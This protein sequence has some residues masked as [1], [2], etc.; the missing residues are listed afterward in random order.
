M[1]CSCRGPLLLER[2]LV[3]ERERDPL[4]LGSD[5]NVTADLAIGLALLDR[6]VDQRVLSENR[7][8]V[9]VGREEA[10]VALE[11]GGTGLTLTRKCGASRTSSD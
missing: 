1:L 3:A 4:R 7:L 6:N 9:E 11:G 10:R 8:G 5:A 2:D